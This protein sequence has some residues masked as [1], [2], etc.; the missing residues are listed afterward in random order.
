MVWRWWLK[1]A[2]NGFFYSWALLIPAAAI[3]PETMMPVGSWGYPWALASACGAV[4]W[5]LIAR[6]RRTTS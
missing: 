4:L 6:A 3:W 2:V 1:E 5:L